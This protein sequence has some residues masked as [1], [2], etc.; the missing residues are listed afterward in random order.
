MPSSAQHLLARDLQ[1]GLLGPNVVRC[2][3]AMETG[4]PMLAAGVMGQ[5]VPSR[6]AVLH[7]ALP[8]PRGMA[9]QVQR[10]GGRS[11]MRRQ[12]PCGV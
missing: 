9:M 12:L 8:T 1:T 4:A 2:T 3:A 11:D 6:L 7:F 5:P 10:S